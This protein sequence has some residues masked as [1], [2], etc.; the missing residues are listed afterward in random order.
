MSQYTIIQITKLSF[1][2]LENVA[3][4]F[5]SP[6][7]MGFLFQGPRGEIAD[8]I[9]YTQ[10]FVVLFLLYQ[11]IIKK[12]PKRSFVPVIFWLAIFAG[13]FF[14]ILPF[15]K[16][17]WEIFPFIKAV[18]QHRLL[19]LIAFPTSILAGYAVLQKDKNKLFIFLLI[20]ATVFYTILNW[21]QRRVI[22]NI[23]DSQLVKDVP[24]STYN[25][26][27]HFYANS[28]W[29]DVKNPYFNK[30]PGNR[31]EVLQG[32]GSVIE[33]ERTSTKHTYHIDAQTDLEIL[34]NTLYFPGWTA[35]VDGRLIDVF[36]SSKGIVTI[37][38]PKGRYKLDV[39]YKDIL[40]LG[41]LKTISV[42]TLIA[43]LGFFS[44]TFF[45]TLFRSRNRSTSSFHNRI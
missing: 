20:G 45:K 41:V 42:A 16:F 32:K 28:K 39:Y 34:E 23:S 8:L 6:W 40:M 29:V 17:V 31:I 13:L 1:V 33:F 22:S 35:A 7:R 12:I 15:S 26:D 3:T 10:W 36:P 9:G 38:L 4:L 19:V 43:I 18:G 30:I 2:P 25:V 37:S 11:T 14:M 21:G 44:L 27:R 5:Y 24:F